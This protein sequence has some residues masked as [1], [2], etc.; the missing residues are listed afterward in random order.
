MNLSSESKKMNT[1]EFMCMC[2]Y[3]H[4]HTHTH[5]HTHSLSYQPD[6]NLAS[7]HAQGKT[8]FSYKIWKHIFKTPHFPLNWKR[9]KKKK[10]KQT[11]FKVA[12]KNMRKSNDILL[13][14]L[15]VI[16]YTATEL[17]NVISIIFLSNKT[18]KNG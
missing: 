18:I 7:E 3:N 15:N 14:K 1:Q 13:Y 17:T 6:V 5:T 9:Q 10:S 16:E 8:Y 4:T 12:G 11:I 2:A